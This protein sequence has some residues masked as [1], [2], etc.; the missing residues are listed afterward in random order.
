MAQVQLAHSAVGSGSSWAQRLRG[1]RMHPRRG[2]QGPLAPRGAQP[3]LTSGQAMQRR[4]GPLGTPALRVSPQNSPTRRSKCSLGPKPNSALRLDWDC[5]GGLRECIRLPLS[6]S[7]GGQRQ[8]SSTPAGRCGITHASTLDH[9]LAGAPGSPSPMTEGADLFG[10]RQAVAGVGMSAL[11]TGRIGSCHG[12]Q[13]R[14][15]L[16]ACSLC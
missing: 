15:Y 12:P 10:A 14:P 9:S 1:N 3:G 2:G 5:F 6:L 13:R 4:A 8:Q 11:Q 7:V 16:P